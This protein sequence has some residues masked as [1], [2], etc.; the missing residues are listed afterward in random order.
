MT[1]PSPSHA[2]PTHSPAEAGAVPTKRRRRGLRV[3]WWILGIVGG[4]I[5]AAVVGILVW[6]QVGVMQA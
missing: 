4:L 1:E 3:L 2:D 5:L 6:S